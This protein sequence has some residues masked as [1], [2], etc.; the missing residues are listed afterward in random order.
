DISS[1]EVT[2]LKNLLKDKG[3]QCEEAGGRLAPGQNVFC[4][5]I[6]SKIITS[7]FCIVLVNNGKKEDQLIPNANVNMEYGLMLGFNKYVIPFQREDQ[8]LPFNVSGLDT[9]IYNDPNFENKAASAIDL[10]ISETTQDLASSPEP[11]QIIQFFLLTKKLYYADV[12]KTGE[13]D[14]FEWGNLF[15]FNLLNDFSGMNY[16]Y[17]G[18]FTTLRPEIVIWRLKMLNDLL[19]E[20]KNSINDREQLGIIPTE[21][22]KPLESLFTSLNIIILVTSNSD[23][24]SIL[25][26]VKEDNFSYRFEIFSLADMTNDLKRFENSIS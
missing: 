2:I 1:M 6:C 3:I 19:N 5:K 10:A 11:D 15:H 8:S 26:G 7:Q 20:R 24:L 12:N 13:R 21:Q 25:N 16:C 23:K 14:M 22:I 18:N 9:V 17:F 4:H